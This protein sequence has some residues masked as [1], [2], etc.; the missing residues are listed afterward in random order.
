MCNIA[1]YVGLRRAA[2]ILIDMIRIQEGLNGGFYTGLAVHDGAGISYRKTLGELDVLLDRT[3]AYELGG[4]TGI[5]HSRTPSGGDGSWAHPFVTERCGR[6]KMAYVA[7]GSLGAFKDR[8]A[9][10]NLITNELVKSG[11]DIPCK[12]N[13]DGDK[14]NRLDTGEAVHMSDVMCQLI[15]KFRCEGC[16]ITDAMTRAFSTM[17][18]EIVG[19][20]IDEDSPDRIYFSRINMPMFVGF[21]ETGAYLASSPMA[22][23]DSVGSY[24]LLPP[25]SSGTVYRDHCEVEPY[26]SFDMDVMPFD[27]KTVENAKQTALDK[28]AEENATTSQLFRAFR[29][30]MP[31]GVLNQSAPIVYLALVDLLKNGTVGCRTVRYETDG[32]KAPKTFFQLINS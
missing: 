20:V 1:G 23:P 16:S 17:P 3:D 27:E 11:Y 15:Y 14:Y 12:I 31:C 26:P 13:F 7:N 21:D 29:A 4:S 6:V 19:L 9:E 28:L 10:Y 2:P 24:E 8:N 18:A 22:F 25:L 5:M 30:E 32:L